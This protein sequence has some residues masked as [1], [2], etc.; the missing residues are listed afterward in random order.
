[1]AMLLNYQG[2]VSAV[3]ACPVAATSTTRTDPGNGYCY[4]TADQMWKW[5]PYET[6]YEGSYGYNGWLYSGSY[7]VS[8]LFLFGNQNPFYP[9]ESS[10]LHSDNTPLFSDA[11]WVDGW[12]YETQHPAKNLYT[13]DGTDGDYIGRFTIARH[14]TLA[15]RNAPTLPSGSPAG[16]PGSINIAFWDGHVSHQKLTMLWTLDWHSGWTQPAAIPNVP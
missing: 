11:M 12:P 16:M 4:G 9:T 13:G 3:R 7:N 15:P 14:G 5:G 6:N 10:I 1:M 2:N 8:G